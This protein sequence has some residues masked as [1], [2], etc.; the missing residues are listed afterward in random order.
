MNIYLII[1]GEHDTCFRQRGSELWSSHWLKKIPEDA[2]SGF[3]RQTGRTV[4]LKMDQSMD[5]SSSRI[6]I[7][8]T[9]VRSSHSGWMYALYAFMTT[10]LGSVKSWA[11]IN[12]SK[13][14]ESAQCAAVRICLSAENQMDLWFKNSY[15]TN[16]AGRR[17]LGYLQ[18]IL[19]L[20]K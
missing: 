10:L 9:R 20:Q 11:P 2:S 12:T 14:W 4:P 13:E 17:P 6:A 18:I 8:L 5:C 16:S 15:V 19:P 1:V 3:G 7:S